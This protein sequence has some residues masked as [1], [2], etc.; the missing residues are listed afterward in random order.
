MPTA[1]GYTLLAASGGRR[2]RS[3]DTYFALNGC[4]VTPYEPVSNKATLLM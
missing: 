2:N 3:H 4:S 1:A